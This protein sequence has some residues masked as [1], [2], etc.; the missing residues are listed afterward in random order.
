[1]AILLMTKVI[2]PNIWAIIADNVALKKGSSLGLLKY[3]SIATLAVYVSTYWLADFWAMAMAMFGF[4]VFWNACLPQIE[5]ATLNHL[6]DKKDQYGL[7][8]LWGSV[9]FIVTVSGLGWLMDFT[10]PSAIMPA[11][12]IALVCLFF[13]S[14]LMRDANLAR[15]TN[16]ESESKRMISDKSLVIPLAKLL[17]Q[18]V[19]IL[20]TLCVLMQISHAPFYTFFSIYLESYGYSKFHIGML[21]SIGVVFEIAIFIF[22]YRLLRRFAL[23]SLLIFTF[24]VAALR[25]ILVA[26]FPEQGSVILFTQILHAITYGLYHSVMIQLIDTL[27]Q[28][29]Y[30]IRGQALY[31][32]VTFGLGGAI[33]SFVS[34][35]IWST[36]GQNQ[37]F[38]GAGMLMFLVFICSLF[39]V[40]RFSE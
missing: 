36:F 38:Y 11:G 13:A 2:A 35:Y 3:A 30:Q 21:W 22:G 20:L 34:G 16:G 5:A 12:A 39:F 27:F 4:C 10:G 33:G 8:R 28:G 24:L 32:G 9:G 7:I 18:R 37:L 14:L 17:N 19:L 40:G 25:W 23:G 26:K 6:A 31:S 15:E 29:R 1:M